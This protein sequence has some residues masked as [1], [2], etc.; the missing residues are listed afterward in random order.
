MVSPQ[1]PD[2]ARRLR[3]EQTDVEK[4]LWQAL[5]SRQLDT[6]KFRRQH[7]VGPFIADFCCVKSK[8]IIELDGG[9]HA[10]DSDADE[11]RS[12]FLAQRGYRVLRFWNHEVLTNIQG[13]LERILES[14]RHPSESLSTWPSPP[15]GRR[16]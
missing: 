15:R 1:K 11:Q 9:Q 2:R 8:L 4:A 16:K 14:T 6:L 12:D 10:L 7:P 5:R 3:R 13:V